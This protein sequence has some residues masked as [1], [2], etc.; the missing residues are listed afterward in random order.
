MQQRGFFITGTDTDVGKT[1][2]GALLVKQLYAKG[3][4]IQPRKPIESGCKNLN[5]V[6]IPSD[7][8]QYHH[9]VN[10]TINLDTI[11]PY[12]FQD[13]VAPPQAMQQDNT[14]CLADLSK[15]SLAAVNKDDFLVVEGAGGLYSPIANDGSNSDLAKELALPVILVVANRVGCINHTLLTIDALQKNNLDLRHIVLNDMQSDKQL[16]TFNTNT[17]ND[18]INSRQIS[19][20]SLQC[21]TKYLDL[22]TFLHTA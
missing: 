9:A 7:G 16:L 3:I 13:A 11:T 15:A 6:L 17:I 1:F 8:E 22:D 20:H 10:Q 18:H 2:F 19:I 21:N 14:V 4:A 5:G 12:R